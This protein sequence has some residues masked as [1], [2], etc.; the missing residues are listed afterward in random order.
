MQK[1]NHTLYYTE[2]IRYRFLYNYYIHSIVSVFG[3]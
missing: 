1:F 2:N 3:H